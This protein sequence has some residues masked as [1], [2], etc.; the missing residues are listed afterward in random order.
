MYHELNIREKKAFIKRDL[1]SGAYYVKD[2]K[3]I[4]R[5]SYGGVTEYMIN[6]KYLIRMY[7]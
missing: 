6:H 7:K 1:D 4:S 5:I 3:T 2:I